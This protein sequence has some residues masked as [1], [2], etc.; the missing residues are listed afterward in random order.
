[1]AHVRPLSNTTGSVSTPA[2]SAIGPLPCGA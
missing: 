1:M 2:P